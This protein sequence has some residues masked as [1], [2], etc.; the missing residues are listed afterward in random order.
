V[1]YGTVYHVGFYAVLV[2]CLLLVSCLDY[3]LSLRME[4][5]CSSETSVDLTELGS[6]RAQTI[7]LLNTLRAC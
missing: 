5:T 6:V 7:T 3:C 2:V 4:T 1:G